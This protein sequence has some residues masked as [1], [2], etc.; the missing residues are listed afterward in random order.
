MR[1]RDIGG[2][3]VIDFID[4]S[5]K[6]NRQIVEE[7]A[8]EVFSHVRAKIKNEPISPL[9]GCMSLLRQR[10]RS[11]ANSIMTFKNVCNIDNLSFH[12]MRLAQ[13]IASEAQVKVIQLQV[14][15]DIGTFLLN[16]CREIVNRISKASQAEIQIIPNPNFDQTKYSIK[17][18][19]GANSQMDKSYSLKE[20]I[21]I[22][23]P[24]SRSKQRLHSST[25]VVQ[26]RHCSKVFSIVCFSFKFIFSKK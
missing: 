22:P 8:K 19:R 20:E 21:E 25:P 18:I 13:S 10:L 9:T 15:V 26:I 2:I 1:L 24:E 11:S 17:S 4:M 23:L 12:L 16:E 14:S 6:K 7:K 3:V 5:D